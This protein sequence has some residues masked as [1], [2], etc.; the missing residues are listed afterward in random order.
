MS[1]SV[2]LGQQETR[3]PKISGEISPENFPC[4]VRCRVELR[5]PCRKQI[6]GH[7]VHQMNDNPATIK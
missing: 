3:C 6:P 5:H 7:G 1:N 4:M 2:V